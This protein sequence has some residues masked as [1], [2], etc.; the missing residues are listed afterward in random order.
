M[1]FTESFLPSEVAAATLG[2]VDEAFKDTI[3]GKAPWLEPGSEPVVVVLVDVPPRPI[4]IYPPTPLLV[5]RTSV[6]GPS[7]NNEAFNAR[8]KRLP[9][10]VIGGPPGLNVSENTTYSVLEFGV[11]KALPSTIGGAWK[12]VVR[13][14]VK[15]MV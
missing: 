14:S 3:D 6:V 15:V 1:Y 9:K 2:K 8:L 5:V 4:H 12:Y 10:A 13:I 7:T 11:K